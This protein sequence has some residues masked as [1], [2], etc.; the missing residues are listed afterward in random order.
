MECADAA[1]Y[2]TRGGR[3]YPLM[4]IPALSVGPCDHIGLE[5]RNGSGKSTLVRALL[6][7]VACDLPTMTI[8]QVVSPTE[9]RHLLAQLH[10]LDADALSQVVA[11]YARLNA[12]PD[13][14]MAGE[15]PSPGQLQ[16]LRLC[17]GLL[18]SPQLMVLDEPTN[19]LDLNS[20]HTL[21]SFLHSYRGSRHRGESR[22]LVP[23]RSLRKTVNGSA[24]RLGR[25]SASSR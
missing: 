5:G 14:L 4:L 17:L 3:Y 15:E 21:A 13:R 24:Y 22:A 1:R 12:D 19:H 23:R 16:K 10:A 20:K 6:S 8:E 11:A 9:G 18:H 7:S 2:G 25:Q